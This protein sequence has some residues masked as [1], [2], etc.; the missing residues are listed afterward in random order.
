[1]IRK[2]NVRIKEKVDNPATRILQGI[3]KKSIDAS[4][5]TCLPRSSLI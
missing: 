2:E 4:I 5:F 3:G 1:M